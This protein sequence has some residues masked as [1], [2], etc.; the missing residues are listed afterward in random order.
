MIIVN[1]ANTWPRV[2]TGEL[3]AASATLGEW[4]NVTDEAIVQFGDVV[5]GNYRG[6]VVTAFDVTGFHRTR[7][8]LVVFKG[9]PSQQ[10]GSLVGGP[11]PVRWKRGQAR[12]IFYLA[13]ESLTGETS[14][15]GAPASRQQV[16]VGS[17]VLT[18]ESDGTATLSVPMG[19]TVTVVSKAA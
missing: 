15:V 3:S 13:T 7:G 2:L 9:V 4:Y 8:G 11:S 19:G 12:P 16:V 18:V 10:F 14:A 5:L 1:L 6:E 17:F